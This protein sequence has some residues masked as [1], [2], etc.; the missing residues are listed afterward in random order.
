M[1]SHLS[2]CSGIGGLDLAVGVPDVFAEIDPAPAEVLARHWP[3]VPNIGDWT[4]LDRFPD[5]T[6]LI[7]GGL[8]CQPV[9]GAGRGRTDSDERYLFDDFVRI[10]TRTEAR[11]T[12]ILENVRGILYPRNRGPFGR[13]VLGLADLGYGLRWDCVRASDA[14]APHKRE[15][16]FCVARHAD[17]ER[18]HGAGPCGAGWEEPAGAGVSAPHADGEPAWRDSGT[19]PGPQGED[20]RRG[21]PA[22]GDRSSHGAATAPDPDGDT[23]TQRDVGQIEPRLDASCR[24]DVGGCGL[25]ALRESKYGPAVERWESL[26]RPAPAPLDDRDRLAVPFVEW[27]MGFPDGFT[28]PLPRSKALKALGNAVVPQQ[29]ALALGVLCG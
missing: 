6:S 3:G 4:A 26:T 13:L 15:R 24:D 21:E 14:G 22:V 17:S 7:S 18:T 5:D 29:A 12:V 8:P 11:P 16:W 10:L 1:S 28:D 19:A 2:L 25:E 23:G 27:M 20:V 9:S